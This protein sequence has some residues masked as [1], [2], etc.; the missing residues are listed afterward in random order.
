M[1]CHGSRGAMK[2]NFGVA[3]RATLRSGHPET[4]HTSTPEVSICPMGSASRLDHFTAVR[5]AFRVGGQIIRL[6][7][8]EERQALRQLSVSKEAN[9]R[10][11][12]Y[13]TL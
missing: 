8:L 1:Y 9:F 7:S 13:P 3:G 11:I 10:L 6:F 12:R 4:E 5:Q 2:I